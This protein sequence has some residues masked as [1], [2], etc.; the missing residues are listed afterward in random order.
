LITT[1]PTTTAMPPIKYIGLI[2][3]DV[4]APVIAKTYWRTGR[5]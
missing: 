2:R 3:Q 4:E 1:K 5:G